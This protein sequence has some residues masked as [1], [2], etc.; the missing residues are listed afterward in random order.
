MMLPYDACNGR[1]LTPANPLSVACASN[2]RTR[3]FPVLWDSPSERGST[4]P[5]QDY[6]CWRRDAVMLPGQSV[7]ASR[8][9][10]CSEFS[11]DIC[12]ISTA[13]AVSV[14]SEERRVGK[15]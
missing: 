14:R 13:Y 2:P 3:S 15:E 9:V 4:N 8:Y 1:W 11:A 5:H 6:R 12:C 7:G 10:Y